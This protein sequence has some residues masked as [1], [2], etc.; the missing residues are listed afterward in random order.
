MNEILE[1]Q[2]GQVSFISGLMSGFA[3][4]IAVQVFRSNVK[5]PLATTVYILLTLTSLLFLV[6]LYIEVALSLRTAGIEN[7]SAD[8]LK[9]IADIRVIGTSAATTALFLFVG[10]IGML[11]CLQS[12]IAGIVTILL[13]IITFI[14]LWKA[15][16]MIFGLGVT[17]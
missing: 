8:L 1:L 7:F 17:V 5:G 12:R 3:L 11:G 4:S 14:A 10:S 2:T 16:I 9:Q 15:R 13:A 6:G